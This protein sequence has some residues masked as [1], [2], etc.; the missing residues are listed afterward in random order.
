M[1]IQE[2]YDWAKEHDILD[3]P[4]YKHNN[5]DIHEI[6]DKIYLKK[7]QIPHSPEMIVLD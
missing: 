4:I 7:D 3:V 5:F 6:K 2:L 1:N